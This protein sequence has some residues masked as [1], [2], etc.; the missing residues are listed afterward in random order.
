MTSCRRSR[1]GTGRRLSPKAR[2]FGR[3]SEEAGESYWIS[4][5]DLM[6]SLL[7]VFILA[8]VVLVLQLA[9]HQE[10]LAAQENQ[11]QE[12]QQR[13]DDQI[14]TLSTAE[15]VRR[16]MLTEIR[17]SLEE[18]G[19]EVLITE[20]NSVLSIPSENL[21]FDASS[22][23]L[24][25]EFE[26]VARTIGSVVSTS[27]REDDRLEYLDTIFVEGHTDNAAFDGLE[28]TGNWGLSTFRAIT[29]WRFWESDLPP[30]LRLNN[31]RNQDGEPLVS[32]SG[33][34][35]TRPVQAEQSSAEA[36]ALNRRIDIRFTVVRPTAED[37]ESISESIEDELP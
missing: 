8:V 23:D 15:Q 16:D 13:F 32:V 29:L 10:S 14:Q 6:S 36:R 28:G 12:Q 9:E 30:D 24:D 22:Y 5:T 1:I 33:Y 19:I 27:I 37:L 17:D 35:E 21:G 26:P 31:L 7:F 3:K 20:N 2:R 4:F 34:G 11:L 18:Q 25:P